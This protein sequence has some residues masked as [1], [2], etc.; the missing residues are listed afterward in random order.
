[1]E[2]QVIFDQGFL[3]LALDKPISNCKAAVIV[4]FFFFFFFFSSSS[5]SFIGL[6]PLPSLRLQSALDL[7]VSCRPKRSKALLLSYTF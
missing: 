4:F 1:L 3:P 5:S 2:G 6:N 7:N